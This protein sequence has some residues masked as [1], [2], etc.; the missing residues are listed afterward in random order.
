MRERL[1]PFRR[2][3]FVDLVARQVALFERERAGL[4]RDAEAALHAYNAAE[5]DEAETRYGDYLDLVDTGQD[6]LVEIRESYA[7]TL[8]P[9]TADEYRDVFNRIV[10]K[11]LPRFGL[12][13]E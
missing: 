12:E 9:E 3:R 2:G 10:R 1:M 13:L 11:R 8:D 4:I 5:R 6:E 7:T